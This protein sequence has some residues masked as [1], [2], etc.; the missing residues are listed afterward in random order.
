MNKKFT[1]PELI[2]DHDKTLLIEVASEFENIASDKQDFIKSIVNNTS[3]LEPLEVGHN[4]YRICN[5]GLLAIKLERKLNWNKGQF[6]NDNAANAMLYR[7]IRTKYVDKKVV[8][9]M[10]KYEV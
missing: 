2:V 5:M 6:K 3:S 1:P 7:P 4:V 9:W 8:D 10:G